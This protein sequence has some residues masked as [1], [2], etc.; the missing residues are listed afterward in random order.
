[1]E[2]I[3][4]NKRTMAS[5]DWLV[6]A[7]VALAALLFAYVQ[8]YLATSPI[9]FHD[10]TFR[11]MVG[12]LT[13]APNPSAYVLLALTTL[14]L[15][16]RRMFP[17][18]VYVFVIVLYSFAQDSAPGYAFSIIGPVIA[19]FTLANERPRGEVIAA[20]ALA[21]L[22]LFVATIPSDN[23]SVALVVRIQN[24]SYMA[25]AVAGGVAWRT[26]QNSVRAT[27]QRAIEAE[28]SRET[29]AARRVEEERVRIA[30]EIHDITAHSLS[31][32]GIQ[33]AAAEKLI[34]RNP[35]AAREAIVQVRMTSKSAL[36][37][38]R[39]M[40]GV[41][42]NEDSEAEM[43]PTN[44]T[45]RMPDL[46]EYARKAGLDVRYDDASYQRQCAPAFVD[47]ALFGIAREAVTNTVRHA[48]AKSLWIRLAMADGQAMLVVE[49]DGIGSSSKTVSE[50]SPL[51]G[52]GVQGMEERVRVLHGT[53]SAGDR[54]AGGYRVQVTLPLGE[55]E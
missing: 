36:E 7:L 43:R 12:I 30:R 17:W 33:A 55:R 22:L 35:E 34:D 37:E 18:P 24:I 21:V 3:L 31:A 29:E 20:A 23:D 42:R 25:L 49:D 27:E 16:L 53:F 10:E 52:H 46:C 9:I 11:D 28:R 6:D 54:A 8:L 51:S 13:R 15:A 4:I 41:L 26:Y 40:I 19:L 39:S 47:V 1:M 14:P 50:H 38:I 44:G 5:R 48:Q 32:V 2:N 45:D